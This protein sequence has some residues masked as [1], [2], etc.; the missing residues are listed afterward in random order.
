MSHPN[1]V[2]IDDTLLESIQNDNLNMVCQWADEFPLEVT[3]IPIMS[4]FV[5]DFIQLINNAS[6][7]RIL[8]SESEIE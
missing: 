4:A 1:P 2:E 5:Y 6:L 3:G 8:S 7:K